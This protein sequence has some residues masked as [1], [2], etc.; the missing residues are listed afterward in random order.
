MNEKDSCVLVIAFRGWSEIL[1]ETKV[2]KRG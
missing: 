1:R 2:V